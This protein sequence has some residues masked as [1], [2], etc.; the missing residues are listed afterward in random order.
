MTIC[1][2]TLVRFA[3]LLAA[4]VAAASLHAAELQVIASGLNNPRGLDFAPTGALY[5]AEAGVGGSGPTVAGHE[6][7][8]HFGLSGSITRVF[9]GKQERIVTGLPSLA[10]ENGAAA[11]G[12]S[13][14]SFG[15]FGYALVTIGLGQ[16][17]AVRNSVLGAAGA[18]MGTL[19]Q[20]TQS[21]QMKLVADI[22]AFE[23]V[24]DP[25]GHGP[26]SNPNG[27][28]SDRAGTAYVTD[29][30]ANALFA[31]SANGTVSTV[32]VFPNRTVTTPVFLPQPPFPPQLSMQAVPT[33]VVRGPDGALY[34]SQLT[35]FPFPV[36]AAK[37]YRV[38]PGSAPTVFAE[39]FTNIIDLQFDASGNLYVLEIDR[40]SLLGPQPVGRLA[41]R[42]AGT[43]TVE[44]VVSTGLVMPTGMVIGPDGA[45]YISNYGVMAGIGEVVR[46]QP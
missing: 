18:R 43:G 25:D 28:W 36:G 10:G 20:M 38:V 3:S 39:G 33:N 1:L 45:I 29:A 7:L 24:A 27:V 42:N 34:V 46:V 2:R 4:T 14:I 26:D 19:Q 21:G 9:K 15:Q 35:G 13:A 5:I 17:P 12:P 11:I 23:G 16:N 44:T 6:G 37:V 40:D 22:A 30:G 32:A 31:V 41:R 8:L